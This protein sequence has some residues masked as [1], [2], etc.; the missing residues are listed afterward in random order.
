MLR[1]DQ[2]E[3]WLEEW[4]AELGAL[5]R[6]HADGVEG[7]P[8]ATSFA[9]GAIPHAVWTRTEG[10]TMDQLFQ[11]LKYALRGLRR[12]PG[13]AFVAVLT[14]ALGI[15]ANGAIFS[16]VNGL[17]L[18]DPVGVH[19]P[20]RLVQVARSYASAPRWDNFSWP[21]LKLI[22][23]EDRAFEGVAGHRGQT[24]ILGRGQDVERVAGSAVTGNYF[25]VLGVRPFVGRLLQEA[26]EAAD[27]DP[28]VVLS[29]ALWQGRYGADA[30][31]IG[32]TVPIGAR[33]HVVVG[34]APPGFVGIVNVGP[35][36]ELWVPATPVHLSTLSAE[37][38]ELWG[39]SWIDGFARLRDD[40]T[41]GGAR[42]AM[43]S[44]SA[45]LQAASPNNGDMIVE[46]EAGL[47]LD[48]ETR[49]AA[50]ATSVV[51]LVIVGLVL[52]IT[53]T[54]VANLFL[55]RA[56]AR[57]G[58]VAVRQAL[59]A[60]RRRLLRQMITESSVLALLAT[61]LAAP[62]VALSGRLL[63]SLLPYN[64]AVSLSPDVRVYVAL[65]ITGLVAGLLFGAAPAW[66][67]ARGD[68]AKA[69]RDAKATVDRSRTRLRD[70]L[71]V[72]QLALS[73]GLVSGTALLGRSVANASSADAGFDATGVLAGRVDLGLTGRYD[74][75]SGYA[76]MRQLFDRARQEPGV[77]AATLASQVPLAGGHARASVRRPEDPDEFVEA[78]FTVV[79]PDYF[80]TMGIPIVRG[81]ALRGFDQEPEPVIVVNERLAE[82]FWPGEEPI[83]QVLER[84]EQEW[85]VVGVSGDVRLRSLRAQP[86]PAVYYPI[87][88]A[89]DSWMALHIAGDG[90]RTPAR[91]SLS[92]IISSVDPELPT[93]AVY[94]LGRVQ[95]ESMGE[96]RTIGVLVGAFA[97]LALILAAVGLYGLI[98]FTASQ[99]VRELGIRMALGA[100]PSSLMTL[101][102]GRGAVL[103][104]LGVGLGV[105]V[106]LGLGGALEGLLYGVAPS[107]APVLIV[108]AVVL[109]AA[110]AAASGIPAWKAS[111]IDA[112]SS[113]RSS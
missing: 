28:V 29:H 87:D 86:N 68:A 51:L 57:R 102:V 37:R 81:R 50:R 48:P 60:S 44:V 100:R 85:R 9:L 38:V 34:V 3:E 79:G 99:R 69:L 39:F 24:F 73:L 76:L 98:S 52:L 112:A 15:G 10:W 105:L 113:L 89:Y 83:G 1:A 67:S 62:L 49:R 66:S 16:L 97:F 11:D 93:L 35:R 109:L 6:A 74:D 20:D 88:H 8:G 108:S 72:A 32:Q 92:S 95:T 59:G 78:E 63:P 26:D 55:A 107:S 53:C 84:A 75:A 2:R 30:Q 101:V 22:A 13:F 21:A 4:L 104:V 43:E 54:N 58:E 7:L 71:V 46:L 64:V 36:P 90:G 61:A 33:P 25:D 41:V 94:D 80:A 5:E 19:E 77:R 65:G 42:A 111:R 12:S 110:A 70:V 96:T 47:G 18:R 103:S 23:E 27:S 106:S 82:H 17:V 40:V 31:L 45:Q 14:L 56:T 91:A